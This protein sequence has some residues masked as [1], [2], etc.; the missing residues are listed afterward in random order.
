MP[1]LY[2]FEYFQTRVTGLEIISDSSLAC[3]LRMEIGAYVIEQICF[4][5]NRLKLNNII[6]L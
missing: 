5:F 3:S 1:A 4:N 2:L 6:C